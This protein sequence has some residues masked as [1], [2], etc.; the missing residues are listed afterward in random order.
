MKLE[1]AELHTTGFSG[2]IGRG[3]SATLRLGP[4]RSPVFVSGQYG[5]RCT[6]DE[7]YSPNQMQIDPGLS[8]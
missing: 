2:I 6:D 1:D 5:E 4:R 8:K 3:R 7:G